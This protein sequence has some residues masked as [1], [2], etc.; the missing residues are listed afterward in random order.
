MCF[1]DHLSNVVLAQICRS[2]CIWPSIPLENGSFGVKKQDFCYNHKSKCKTAD[3]TLKE[4]KVTCK[5]IQ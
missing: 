2:F 1:I 3:K 4:L 5:K